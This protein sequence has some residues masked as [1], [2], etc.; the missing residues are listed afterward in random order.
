MKK[1]Y[2][3]HVFLLVGLLFSTSCKS[4]KNISKSNSEPA[5]TTIV[6][7]E[8]KPVKPADPKGKE[9]V[10][11]PAKEKIGTKE[12]PVV[13]LETN[14]G[15]IKIQLNSKTPKHRDNFIK[16]AKESYFDGTLF[17]RVIRDFM[18]QGGDPNSKNA[19]P[20][21]MLGMG[22]PSYT[23]DAEFVPEYVHTKGALA[24][25]RQGDNVNPKRASSGSQFYIVHGKA[26]TDQELDFFEQRLNTKYTTEQRNAYK[27]LGGTPFLDTQYT[28]FGRVIEGFDVIDKIAATKCAAGDRPVED[29]KM[30]ITILTEL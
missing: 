14:Y 27:T 10:V 11:Q 24:A 21:V 29:I 4:K 26:L 8:E 13:L 20:G 5:K 15:N 28:V 12:E 22:G 18:I 7:E 3:L 2:L 1:T 23:V 6:K 30:K 19:A 9:E 16:L 25:A 17:H